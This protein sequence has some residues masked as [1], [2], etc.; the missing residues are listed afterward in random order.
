MIERMRDLGFVVNASAT[1]E[2]RK[3]SE[4]FWIKP[5]IFQFDR[6]ATVAPAVQS[7]GTGRPKGRAHSHTTCWQS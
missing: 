7:A 4:L 6:L 3:A 1:N 2:L 5:A